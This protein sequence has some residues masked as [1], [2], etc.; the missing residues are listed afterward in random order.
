MEAI[1]RALGLLEGPAVREAL[2]APL[3]LMTQLQVS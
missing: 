2:L 3:R 1:A